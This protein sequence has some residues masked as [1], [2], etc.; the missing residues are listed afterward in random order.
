MNSGA[1]LPF[2]SNGLLD[3]IINREAQH[4]I[5]HK[6]SLGRAI[7]IQQADNGQDRLILLERQSKACEL[8]LPFLDIQHRLVNRLANIFFL[9]HRPVPVN[10]MLHLMLLHLQ[11]ALLVKAI[12]ELRKQLAD[13]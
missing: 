13:R 11:P 1:P 9:H 2:G 4:I 3:H 7:V 10:K 12:D 6:S 8:A 5:G